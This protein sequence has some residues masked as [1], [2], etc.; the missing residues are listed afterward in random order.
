VV[1]NLLARGMQPWICLCYGNDLD[2]EEAKNVFGAVGCAPIFNEEQKTGWANYV[3]ATVKH[4]EGR[5]H[6]WEVWNEPDGKWC[7]KHGVNAEE[8]GRFVVDTAAAIRAVSSDARII[9]GSICLLDNM[10]FLDTALADGMGDV[11]DAFT[12]HEYTP[13]DRCGETQR[14]Q[15]LCGDLAWARGRKTRRAEFLA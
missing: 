7:W 13:D 6:D 15:D 8:Y 1:D 5:I 4:F 2:N 14:R 9:G 10:D 11:I 12:F 3:K